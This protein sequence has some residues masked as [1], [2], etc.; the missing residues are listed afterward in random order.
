[1]SRGQLVPDETI[2]RVFLDR[3]EQPDARGGAI[4]DGFPRTRGPGR[5]ARRA[6]SP[7]AGRR[8]D[9]AI[10]IDVPTE[11][12]DPADGEPPDL[13]R[14][15][16]RLQ[17]RLEPAPS[18][19]RLRHR[20]LGRSIQRP[21]DQEETVRAR[22]SEQIPPLARGRRPLPDAGRPADGRRA[23]ADRARSARPSSP[24]RRALAASTTVRRSGRLMVTRK[25]R[26]EIEKMR[27]RR[28]G[29]W[30]RSSRSS[31][32]SSSPASRPATSTGSP[33]A[34]SGRPARCRRSRATATGATRSRPACA[35]RSTTRSS[36][37][38]PASGTIRDGQIVS[39]DAGA[40]YDGWH[41]DGARTFVVGDA[42][43]RGRASSSTRPAWR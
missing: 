12:L 2:V 10:F 29:S 30:P 22:M 25:S 39:V 37:G 43:A 40:I 27:D 28:A 21:D 8:V 17:P 33:S 1:M 15:R 4:L 5:G 6:R 41:G 11:D 26:R 13:H 16:P 18:R 31:S 35:S 9:R 14:E 34:T 3:L 7:T 23:R 38:S 36:T 42:D 20:R 24:R 19:R 32:P